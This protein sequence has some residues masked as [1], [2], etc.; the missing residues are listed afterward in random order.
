[1]LINLLSNAIK[2]TPSGG[3]VRVDAQ[4]EAGGTVR[5]AVTDS[6]IG[7]SPEDQ[8]RIFESY[9]RAANTDVRRIEGSGLGLSLVRSMMDLHGGIVTVDSFPGR[10]STFTLIFP[11]TR[12]PG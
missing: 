3:R 8:T 11:P 7:I 12:A 4:R 9:Q 5:I 1:M 6:G 10:G 2:F